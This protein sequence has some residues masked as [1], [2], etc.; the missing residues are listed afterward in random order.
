MG[1][2]SYCPLGWD[3]VRFARETG[4]PPSA[5]GS[6]CGAIVSYA[7]YLSHVCPLEYDLLFERFLDPN[8]TEAPDIDIDFCQDRREQV[9]QYVKQQYGADS[10]AQTGTFGPLAAK[11][12]LND[13]GRVPH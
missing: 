3:L 7:L 6:G 13:A 2:A 5:R 10:V 8:R 1:S 11:A 12:D 4:I 9:I